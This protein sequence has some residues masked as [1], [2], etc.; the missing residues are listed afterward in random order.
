MEDFKRSHEQPSNF[1]MNLAVIY[2]DRS[3]QQFQVMHGDE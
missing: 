2:D 1:T 3:S